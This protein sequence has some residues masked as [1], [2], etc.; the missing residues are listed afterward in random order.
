MPAKE[1]VTTLVPERFCRDDVCGGD[2]S[3]EGPCRPCTVA[4]GEHGRLLI[5]PD[6]SSY[7]CTQSAGI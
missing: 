7:I 2:G 3:W 5:P 6:L 1:G 4:Q